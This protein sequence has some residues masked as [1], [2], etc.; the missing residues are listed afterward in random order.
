[1]AK[2]KNLQVNHIETEPDTEETP[3]YEDIN[4]SWLKLFD[5]RIFVHHTILGG[6]SSGDYGVFWI[7]PRQ[8]SVV[9]IWETHQTD[10]SSNGSLNI[11]KLNDG[12]SLDAGTELLS[13]DIDLTSNAGNVQTGTLTRANKQIEKGQRLALKD[14]GTLTAIDNVTVVIELKIK[15]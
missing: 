13:S 9:N 8:C 4:F 12:D 10:G 2:E 11:E 5:K 6:A 15:R 1:M 3:F 14:S 7:A